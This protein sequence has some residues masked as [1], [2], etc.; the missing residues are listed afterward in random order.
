[1]R[2]EALEELVRNQFYRAVA[3][4]RLR[5]AGGPVLS[6]PEEGE[7]GLTFTATFEVYPE[8]EIQSLEGVT[9]EK[10]VVEIT[11]ADVDKVIQR[12]RITARKPLPA[13]LPTSP[14]P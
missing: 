2:A 9:I 8:I 14:S 7:A 3:E 13:S 5:P 10:P 1:V 6:E 12:R 4:E 11:D